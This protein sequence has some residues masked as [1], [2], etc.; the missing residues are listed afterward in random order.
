MPVVS[1][2]P[3]VCRR[4]R[5]RHDRRGQSQDRQHRCQLASDRHAL[6]H[7]YALRW[8]LLKPSAESGRINLPNTALSPRRGDGRVPCDPGFAPYYRNAPLTAGWCLCCSG[9]IGSME[10]ERIKSARS[11][12]G[13]P[14]WPCW[15]CGCAAQ[16]LRP[17]TTRWRSRV[18]KLLLDLYD[19]TADHRALRATPVPSRG[20]ALCAAF[21]RERPGADRRA[22]RLRAECAAGGAA[23]RMRVARGRASRSVHS[24]WSRA[25]SRRRSSNRR[26]RVS[27]GAV[28]VQV[29][30]YVRPVR[31]ITDALGPSPS[32]PS[33][34]M[35]S[36][37]AQQ[38]ASAA[39]GIDATGLRSCARTSSSRR[40]N[41]WRRSDGR[42]PVDRRREPGDDPAAR[43]AA[44]RA[45]P[46][47]ERRLERGGQD[48]GTALLEEVHAV[49]PQATLAFCGPQTF[50]DYTS[51]LT[52]LIA[53]G[54][55]ILVD[56]MNFPPQDLMS[57]DGSELAAPI[58]SCSRIRTSRCSPSPGT[59]LAAIGKAPT[60]RYRW[61][62]RGCR[63]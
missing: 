4:G 58:P 5:T 38:R 32:A 59:P 35:R 60:P 19:A 50:I 36:A 31:P 56:D 3:G 24:A 33:G 16:H 10:G 7:C 23:R 51:C 53:A 62:P 26:R 52:Q 47:S 40:P 61:P 11:C 13:L 49:A 14:C 20:T 45:G 63:R 30:A 15:P 46:E 27:C 9:T 17:R 22:F 48:E 57:S 42:R 25:G 44:G 1:G 18:A 28:R 6:P 43:G 8:P 54:A 55:T 2:A 21:R 12:A 39:S 29:P 34:R 37:P 41:R